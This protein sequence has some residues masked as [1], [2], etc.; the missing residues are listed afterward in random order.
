MAPKLYAASFVQEFRSYGQ[1]P[2][3]NYACNANTKGALMME[4]TQLEQVSLS[5]VQLTGRH[6][7]GER[8]RL[9]PRPL[10]K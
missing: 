10:P 2:D 5:E 6:Q 4:I 7:L 8:V 1:S 9:E 3:R